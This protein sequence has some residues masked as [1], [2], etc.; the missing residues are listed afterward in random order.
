MTEKGHMGMSAFGNIGEEID[1]Q[2]ALASA[3]LQNIAAAG[4]GTGARQLLPR[5]VLVVTRYGPC[6]P[7]A[8]VARNWSATVRQNASL[9]A[10]SRTC[11]SSVATLSRPALLGGLH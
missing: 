4:A 10:F 1:K 6:A 5:A 11:G 9:A 7:V 3:A 2:A 8:S